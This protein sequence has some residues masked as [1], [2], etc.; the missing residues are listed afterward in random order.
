LYFSP[1]YRLSVTRGAGEMRAPGG[2]GKS[3]RATGRQAGDHS[4][5]GKAADLLHPSVLLVGLCVDGRA[6]LSAGPGRR[7]ARWA[8][9]TSLNTWYFFSVRRLFETEKLLM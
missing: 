4:A 6:E 9:E 2:S 8:A 1:Q 7:G 3:H 5:G